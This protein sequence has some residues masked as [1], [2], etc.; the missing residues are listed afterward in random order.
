MTNAQVRVLYKLIA[1]ERR[2]WASDHT[3]IGL[4]YIKV[5]DR[6]ILTVD[7]LAARGLA[8][9]KRVS[10]NEVYASLDAGNSLLNE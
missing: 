3:D 1:A 9:V 4:F 7:A 6:D 8:I 10:D 2:Y 5:K